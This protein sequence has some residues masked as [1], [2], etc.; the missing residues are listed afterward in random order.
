MFIFTNINYEELYM[1]KNTNFYFVDI[2]GI[3]KLFQKA[4]YS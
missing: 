1:S 3:G 2:P 4:I